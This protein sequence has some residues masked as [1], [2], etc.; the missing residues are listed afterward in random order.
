MKKRAQKVDRFFVWKKRKKYVGNV[1]DECRGVPRHEVAV[2]DE[3]TQ[4]VWVTTGGV[5]N[6]AGRRVPRAA[7]I[8]LVR[9]D[10]RPT[11]TLNLVSKQQVADE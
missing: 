10:Q 5:T 3:Q 8:C 11:A 6:V 9:A 7:V 1:W 4:S 2:R